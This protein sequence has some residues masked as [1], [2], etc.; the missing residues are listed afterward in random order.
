[1]R[2]LG[3]LEPNLLKEYILENLGLNRREVI[4]RSKIGL[5]FGVIK[6]RKGYLI[7]SS[8][9]VT[10]AGEE[11][12]WYAVNICA[13]DVATSGNRAKYLTSTI[14]IPSDAS[15][16]LVRKIAQEIHKACKKLKISI[17]SGHTEFFNLS[18]PMV[19][20][21]AFTFA[22]DF[23]SSC[24]AKE[25]DLILITK[26]AGIEGTSL[27]AKMIK[28]RS[29]LSKNEI[30]E[31]LK[32]R[33][34]IG[35]VKEA[36]SLFKA[37]CVNA[38][39]DATEGGLLGAL[40]EMAEASN[41]GFQLYRDEVPIHPITLKLCNIFKLDPLKLI[42]SGTLVASISEDKLDLAFR[43]LDK[44]KIKAKVIG[45]FLRK[46]YEI[47]SGNRVEMV[48]EYPE[49]EFWH[50]LGKEYESGNSAK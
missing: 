42:S 32:L 13:N 31:A 19:V 15:P 26:G 14:L 17:V 25:K 18:S 43:V 48:K 20:A 29:L 47:V 46:G 23:V 4:L 33:N 11:V 34:S 45:K 27:I 12:G 50:F 28:D 2:K 9:P 39:H 41:L 8:D 36:T 10:G 37:K 3:K 35:V 6:L 1:M 44:E 24:N 49:D 21:S 40:I 16:N 30:K 38:M 7:V 5:D 22:K